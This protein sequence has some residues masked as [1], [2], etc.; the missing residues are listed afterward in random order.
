MAIE[1]YMG[2]NTN[3]AP[4]RAGLRGSDIVTAVNGATTNL[5]GRAFL[6]WF[7]QQYDT[8][9]RITLSIRSRGQD[10][11]VTYQLTDADH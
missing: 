11:Q 10:K 9:D 7:R 4:Y 3:S 5:V 1:P 8:G 6:V 2:R